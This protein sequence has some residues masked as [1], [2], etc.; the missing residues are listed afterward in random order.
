M[1]SSS[2]VILYFLLV[3]LKP[4]VKRPHGRS[5]YRLEDNIKV[6]LKQKGYENVEWSKLVKDRIEWCVLINTEI[7]FRAILKILEISR[8]SR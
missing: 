1:S 3:S 6:D 5:S 8:S 7:S 4:E 2:E